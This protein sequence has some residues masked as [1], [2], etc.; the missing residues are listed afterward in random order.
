MIYDFHNPAEAVR[1]Q[2]NLYEPGGF[3]GE[4]CGIL[5]C[6]VVILVNQWSQS[7]E[8]HARLVQVDCHPGSHPEGKD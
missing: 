5:L 8:S 6:L 7:C 3:S 1:Q 2:H 4:R